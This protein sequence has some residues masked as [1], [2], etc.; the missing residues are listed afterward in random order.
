MGDRE[1]GH[2]GSQPVKCYVSGGR[3]LPRGPKVKTGGP[4][5]SS[6]ASAHTWHTMLAGRSWSGKLR[7]AVPALYEGICCL[8]WCGSVK[9]ALEGISGNSRL[10]PATLLCYLRRT[11]EFS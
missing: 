11:V 10:A 9:N 2:S 5:E 4:A 7:V 1:Q 6:A 8:Q 3:E